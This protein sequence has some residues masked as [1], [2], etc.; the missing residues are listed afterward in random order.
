MMEG[1]DTDQTREGSPQPAHSDM[2][3]KQEDETT[4]ATK[5][6]PLEDDDEEEEEEDSSSDDVDEEKRQNGHSGA[7]SSSD[8]E[9]KKRKGKEKAEEGGGPEE[10][11]R[12]GMRLVEEGEEIEEG[13]SSVVAFLNGFPRVVLRAALRK[14]VFAK[15]NRLKATC[16]HAGLINDHKA[17]HE[18][19]THTR[20]HHPLMMSKLTYDA[21][22]SSAVRTGVGRRCRRHTQ[23][24]T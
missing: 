16:T 24:S 4:K 3:A 22:P 2:L 7:A 20:P 6:K 8:D 12:G 1:A 14:F 18:V 17:G 10:K 11:V 21:C 13:S 19:P 23:A 5:H 9:E 15:S